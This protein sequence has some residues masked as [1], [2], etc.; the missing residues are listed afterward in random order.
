MSNVTKKELVDEIAERT[1]MPQKD[2][3]NIVEDFLGV[4]AE[5]LSD[6]RNIEIRGF[7]RFKIREIKPRMARN[8][9]TGE[10]VMVQEGYKAVFEISKELKTFITE[11]IQKKGGL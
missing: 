8:P 4:I 6:G 7:G 2:V 11:K 5:R 3:K 10:P 1:N 9:K